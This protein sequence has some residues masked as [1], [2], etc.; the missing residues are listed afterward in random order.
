MLSLHGLPVRHSFS[1]GVTGHLRT[2]FIAGSPDFH[3]PG[4]IKSGDNIVKIFDF[5]SFNLFKFM[6]KFVSEKPI[7][8][9]ETKIIQCW[10][11]LE[12]LLF[13]C[14]RRFCWY[15]LPKK[16]RQLTMYFGL[17]S[18]PIQEKL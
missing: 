10:Q 5:F 1:D 4:M 6:P 12:N 17:N 2:E 16:A 13:F 3:S 18:I 11:A 15:V 8:R 14:F 9:K 7:L